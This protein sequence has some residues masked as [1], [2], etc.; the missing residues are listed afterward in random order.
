MSSFPGFKYKYFP[1]NPCTSGGVMLVVRDSFDQS[2][3][4]WTDTVHVEGRVVQHVLTSSVGVIEIFN[5]HHFN[6]DAAGSAAARYSIQQSINVA[7]MNPFSHLVVLLGDFNKMRKGELRH[8][9][10]PLDQADYVQN[11]SQHAINNT[12]DDNEWELIFESLTELSTQ[13]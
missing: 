13:S 3:V 7:N 11:F 9:I 12:Q 6:L 5:S 2:L 1:C 8:Y 10:D 4:S